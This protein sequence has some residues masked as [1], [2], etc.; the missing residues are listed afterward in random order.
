MLEH[1]FYW[2]TFPTFLTAEILQERKL[3]FLIRAR[4]EDDDDDDD[5]DLDNAYKS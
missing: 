4:D 2:S 1:F 3:S 5:N